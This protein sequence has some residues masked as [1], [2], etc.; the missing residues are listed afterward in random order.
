MSVRWQGSMQPDWLLSCILPSLLFIKWVVQFSLAINSST[1]TSTTL[2][3]HKPHPRSSTTNRSFYIYKIDK[4]YTESGQR[5][6]LLFASF[7]HP[8]Q[9]T[10]ALRY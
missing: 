6:L 7:T 2:R 8:R 3:I 9:P 10:G 4:N 5:T 1:I